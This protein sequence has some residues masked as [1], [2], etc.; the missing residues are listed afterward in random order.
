MIRPIPLVV[1]AHLLLL[2]GP[3]QPDGAAVLGKPF[4]FNLGGVVFRPYGFFENIAEYRTLTTPDTVYTRFGSI[5][6]KES[7]GQWLDTLRHSR[8][9]LH[10]DRRLGS[11][12]LTGYLEIDFQNPAGQQPCQFRQYWGEFS[13]GHWRILAGQGWSLLRPNRAV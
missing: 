7:P 5:P 6:L 10:A 9:N 1:S 12:T 4:S 2:L 11:G 3:A 13:Q 8:M